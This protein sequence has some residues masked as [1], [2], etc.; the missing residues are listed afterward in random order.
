MMP[1]VQ[2]KI[3]QRIAE[4][5]KDIVLAEER[6][7]EGIRLGCHEGVKKLL[8]QL[9]LDLKYLSILVNGAPVNRDEDRKIM[10]FLRIHYNWLREYSPPMKSQDL[11]I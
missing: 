3:H 8:H 5:Q 11:K 4:M 7:A 2:E 1:S 9:E 10:D 6:V